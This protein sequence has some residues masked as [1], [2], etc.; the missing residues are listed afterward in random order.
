MLKRLSIITALVAVSFTVFTGGSSAAT[1]V[2]YNG[3]CGGGTTLA[4]MMVGWERHGVLDDVARSAGQTPGLD[5]SPAN[6][7]RDGVVEVVVVRG[8]WV[9]NFTCKGG[10]FSEVS[11]SKYISAGSRYFVPERLAPKPCARKRVFVGWEAKCGNEQHGDL[12]VRRVC[13]PVY[14]PRPSKPVVLHSVGVVKT[15]PNWAKPTRFGYWV[16]V[17]NGP[18]VLKKVPNDGLRHTVATVRRGSVVTVSEIQTVSNKS[19]WVNDNRLG[20]ISRTV[21]VGNNSIALRYRN[22][23]QA[24]VNV[25]KYMFTNGV[26]TTCVAPACTN[27]E[28]FRFGLSGLNL[29]LDWLVPADKQWHVQWAYVGYAYTLVELEG[30][31]YTV[32]HFQPGNKVEST[33]STFS[34][35][36]PDNGIYVVFV[37]RRFTPTAKPILAPTPPT[38]TPAPKSGE[39]GAGTPVPGVPGG[40]SPGTTPGTGS[41]LKCTD[42]TTELPRDP[43][44]DEYSD[45]F[46]YCTKK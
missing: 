23:L 25:A 28:K 45:M 39:P 31:G 18:R 40:P 1:Q 10:G 30:H 21:R 22:Y 3:A 37:N 26:D 34:F 33:S 41:G 20:A 15:T 7:V 46:G 11:K 13:A 24:Q 36:V 8:G 27:P 42:R 4:D 32:S 43:A 17:N 6:I 29:E 14:K 2:R 38:P 16:T 19:R 12:L 44:S 35:V 9:R 5:G